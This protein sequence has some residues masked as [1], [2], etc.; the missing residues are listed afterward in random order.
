[1]ANKLRMMMDA[2]KERKKERPM[3]G[4]EGFGTITRRGKDVTG[5][6]S[7]IGK[8]KSKLRRMID[9][10]KSRHGTR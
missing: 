10:L 7:A 2:L 5:K 8:R 1:M 9:S 3:K 6:F 4:S